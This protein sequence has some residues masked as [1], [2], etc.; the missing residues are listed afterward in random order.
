M[1]SLITGASGFAG[2]WLARHC[3]EHGD[4][5]FGAS[6]SGRIPG[7]C[8][9]AVAIDL[10]DG[11]AVHQLFTEIEPEVVY[12]LAALSSVGTSWR[13]PS[14]TVNDNIAVSTS[15]LEALRLATPAA[16]T[17]WA[18]SC[19]VYG[20]ATELP[21]EETAA[22]APES[23]YAVSKAAGDMLAGVY[24][25]AHGLSI[26]RVRAFNHAGP[27]QLPIFVVSSIARQAAQARLRGGT[28]T[29]IVTG[30]PLSRRDYTDVRD[31]ARAY[32]MLGRS[33]VGAGVYNV[34]SGIS[35]PVQ[36]L[37]SIAASLIAPIEVEHVVDPARVRAHEVLDSRGSFDRVRA[38][39]G[40]E[41]RTA[42]RET[43]A[44]TFA[45][46]LGEL[47]GADTA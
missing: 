20:A 41:P 13:E 30:N 15:I 26:V 36:E 31:I 43:I 44:D 46:W 39:T 16:R 22:L 29:E 3:A 27:G 24:A 10:R 45:W 9:T 40:W 2:G 47:A 8:G 18:S 23:P 7:G 32:R 38:A 34:C 1:R 4:E 37:V 12:H 42:L 6:R 33:E 14:A 19:E 11:D 5:V 28:S 17:V 35:V 25:R 21:V